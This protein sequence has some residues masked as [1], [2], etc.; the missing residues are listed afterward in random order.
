MA[1]EPAAVVQRG[2]SVRAGLAGIA[3]VPPM[4]LPQ[5]LRSHPG[6]KRILGAEWRKAKAAADNTAT[7]T[8]PILVPSCSIT[9]TVAPKTAV[10]ATSRSP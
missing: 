9:S 6:A 2:A 10:N 4:D 8:I 5:S 7:I 3:I 1:L